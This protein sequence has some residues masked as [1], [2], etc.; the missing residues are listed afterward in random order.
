M[1]NLQ[2]GDFSAYARRCAVVLAAVICGTGVMVG[3]AYSGVAD[4]LRIALVLATATLNAILVACYLMH[5]ISERKTILTV[6]A[7]TV[8]FFISLIF[9]TVWAS[10]DVPGVLKSHA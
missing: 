2:A 9:L 7:F 6:L 1:S 8:F 4:S 3:A 10:Y 5:L